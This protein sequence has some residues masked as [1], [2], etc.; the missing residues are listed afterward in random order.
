MVQMKL[1]MPQGHGVTVKSA[2]LRIIL[3][4]D[5]KNDGNG[6]AQENLRT[7]CGICEYLSHWW[8]AWNHW[9]LNHSIWG[10]H[11]L[12]GWSW[13]GIGSWS[14]HGLGSW[15]WHSIG[16][17]S[18]HGISS[19]SWHGISGW[20]W[21]SLSGWSW[22][23]I[24]SWCRCISCWGSWCGLVQEWRALHSSATWIRVH[25]SIGKLGSAASNTYIHQQF[26]FK[27]DRSNDYHPQP[28]TVCIDGSH[29]YTP[30]IAYYIT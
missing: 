19:W 24:G 29:S 2:V 14:W 7:D 22:H 16:S 13:H 17:W 12:G 28:P 1:C 25:H 15:S 6:C 18:W 4:N 10:W 11:S 27:T 30:R 5:S 21:N 3:G 23:G 9:G 8:T 20:S 26:V